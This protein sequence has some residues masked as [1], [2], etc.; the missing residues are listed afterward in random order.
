MSILL[1]LANS[2]ATGIGVR[3]AQHPVQEQM[4]T[5]VTPMGVLK[6]RLYIPVDVEHPPGLVLL[7]GVHHLGIQD[8][9][10][11]NFSHAL[12]GAGIEVMTPELQDLAD[13]H[14][15]PRSIDQMGISAVV[16]SN[17][18]HQPKVGILGLSFAGG[19]ALLAATRPEYIGNIAF[20]A[21]I[22]AHDDLARV[23]RFFATNTVE[24]PDGTV[25]PFT[26]HPYGVQVLAYSHLEDFFSVQDVPF[27]KEALRLWLWEQADL[28]SKMAGNLSSAGKVKFDQILNH[29]DQIQQQLLDEVKLHGDEMAA[30]SPRGRLGNLSV[31]VLLLH[32]AGDTIIPTS[33]TQWLAKEV[34]AQALK[35]VLI[36]PALG[37]V[38]LEETV[39]ASQKWDLVHFMAQV[40]DREDQL[41]R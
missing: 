25:V 16:L 14:V 31:P 19:M 4:E 7:N 40:V 23:S 36:S 38:N 10:M 30:V 12:A 20:V 15:V 27:A 6:Y 17:Q 33:E 2:K 9:R 18:I 13:Y 28:S 22:G 34:P 35:N 11:I 3:F 21:C 5:A 24:Y 8:P 41:R 39:T 32:G 26:A 29:R 1:R 37:H